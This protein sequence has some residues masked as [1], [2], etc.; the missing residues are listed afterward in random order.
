MTILFNRNDASQLIGRLPGSSGTG[1]VT[2]Q[3][4]NRFHRARTTSAIAA[5]SGLTFG[6]GTAELV[7]DVGVP[8]DPIE[9]LNPLPTAFA[10]GTDVVIAREELTNCW[11]IHRCGGE[12]CELSIGDLPDI[13]ITGME[14]DGEWE[15]NGDCCYVRRYNYLTT[16]PRQVVSVDVQRSTFH[17]MTTQIFKAKPALGDCDSVFGCYQADVDFTNVSV[18]RLGLVYQLQSVDVF[19]QFKTINCPPDGDVPKF[20]VSTRHNVGFRSS[21]IT[22]SWIDEVGV[23]TN[24]GCCT[25]ADDNDYSDTGN[26]P[27]WS[28]VTIW[29]AY[30]GTLTDGEYW[31]HKIFDAMPVDDELIDGCL[32]PCTSDAFCATECEGLCL[33]SE[34]SETIPTDG[35]YPICPTP[36][37]VARTCTFSTGGC[38]YTLDYYAVSAVGLCERFGFIYGRTPLDYSTLSPCGSSTGIMNSTTAFDLETSCVFTFGAEVCLQTPITLEF[39]EP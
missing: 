33:T 2:P 34:P 38:T 28:D 36:A 19:I 13:T 31:N 24:L 27:N 39:P 1:P 11:L 26:E 6:S 15:V 4:Q 22:T 14:A 25:G 9:L 35:G 8:I 10:T 23:Y 18:E 32:A 21:F 29:P 5:A 12:I 17:R 20:I 30:S 7:P 16:Q 37:Y 3:R